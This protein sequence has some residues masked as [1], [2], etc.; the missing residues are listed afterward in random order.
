MRIKD[1][2]KVDRP[3]EKLVKYG[4]K[5][6][7][8]AELLALI[9][10]TGTK[11]ANVVELSR[12][13]LNKFRNKIADLDIK[14][15]KEINGLGETK[16]CQIIACLELAKRLSREE[17][18]QFLSPEDIYNS[19]TDL[20]QSKKEQLL[21]IYLDTRNRE[22]AREIISVGTLNANL[23]HPREVFEPAIK[24]L[25][26]SIILIHNH[27]SGDSDPSGEDLEITKQLVDSGR[28][29]GIE[30]LDHLIIAAD[31]YLSFKE[32]KLI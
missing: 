25:A 10:R 6:L 24:N 22:I 13:V 12:K 18:K 32:K 17:S 7:S 3:Q 20:R 5:K 30:V 19:L 9:L 21:V 23:V 31:S 1:T 11:S 4:V 14:S 29:I 27:P 2:P 15:L 28:I 8:D 16:A 26:A